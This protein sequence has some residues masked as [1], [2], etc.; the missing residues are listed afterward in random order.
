MQASFLVEP[1]AEVDEFVVG[2]EFYGAGLAVDEFDQCGGVGEGVVA[3]GDDGAFWAGVELG[4]AGVPFFVVNNKYAVAGAQEAEAFLPL[5]DL[6]DG[7][8]PEGV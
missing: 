5:F 3:E 2:A 1:V 7:E 6:K 8:V 4:I